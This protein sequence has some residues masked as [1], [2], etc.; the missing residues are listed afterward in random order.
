MEGRAGFLGGGAQL[1]PDADGVE[2]PMVPTYSDA[3]LVIE[4]P[5]SGE[6]IHRYLTNDDVLV[7]EV[8]RPSGV[9]VKLFYA[10]T[11]L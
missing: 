11:A 9:V 7:T 10:R 6:Q 5:S 3:K 2:V 4:K 8:R 1:R